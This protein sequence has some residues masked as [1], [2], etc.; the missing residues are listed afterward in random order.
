MRVVRNFLAVLSGPVTAVAGALLIVT[1]GPATPA[2]AQ[3][4]VPPAVAEDRVRYTVTIDITGADD[5]LEESIRAASNLETLVDEPPPGA[6]G[7]V[8]RAA[9]DI[10][11]FLGALYAEGHYGGLIEMT[12]AGTPIEAEDVIGAVEAAAARGPVPVRV[13]ITAGPQYT[14]G[15]IAFE[16]ADTGR[17]GLPLPIDTSDIGIAPGDPARGADVLAAEGVI[18]DEMRALGYPLASVPSREA[19]ADHATDTLD[20]TFRLSPGRPAVFGPVEVRGADGVDPA[21]IERYAD[22]PAGEAYSPEEVDRIREQ[23]ARLDAFQSVRIVEGDEVTPDGL[24]PLYIEVEERLPRF[25]GFGAAYSTTEGAA[26]NAYW[27]HRNLFGGA[28][29]L[30][31]EGQVSRLFDND[32]E[33]LQYLGLVTFEKPG[34]WTP[35]DNLLVEARAFR[36]R[37][38]A[39]ESHGVGGTVS[40]RR[41]FSRHLTGQI[42]V[43]FEESRITDAFGTNNYTLVGLPVQ[44]DWDSTD[45]RLDPTEGF[46]A[47]LAVSPFFEA[48]GSSLD[49]TVA[50]GSVSAYHAFD[51]EG[52]YIIAGRVAAGTIDGPA[53]EFIPAD[54]RFYAGG[55]GSVRG[56]DY[57]SLSPRDPATGQ[58]IGGKSL[59]EASLEFRLRVTE[60]IGIVPFIDIGGAFASATPDFG[61]EMRAGAELGFRYYT[62]IG[63]IRVNVATPLDPRPGDPNVAVYVGLGQAF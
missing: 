25:I 22:V 33:D 41:R 4:P 6:A 37:P 16:D 44:L 62:A 1:A 9:A 29:R 24:I 27:G 39:Y 20:V 48:V 8:R 31:I 3:E 55:G 63:P 30:R 19:V 15:E 23:L 58:I 7:L 54:R 50:R 43:E 17:P 36:E 60:T 5:N 40:I 42:G 52:R 2:R 14:F 61:D 21:F 51:T 53:L 49:L 38:E 35:A 46:R 18:V 59:F 13:R 10:E 45:N 56:Y 34:I 32:I 57:Q 12:L 47:R 26:L 11:R 28:E